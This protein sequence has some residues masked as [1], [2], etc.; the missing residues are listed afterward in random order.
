MRLNTFLKSFR[1]F[2]FFSFILIA[3]TLAAV[4]CGEKKEPQSVMAGYI[5]VKCPEEILPVISE[6][7]YE[8]MDLYVKSKILVVSSTTN[9]ALSAIFTDSAQVAV[10]T[11]PMSPVERERA[12]A[13]AF[14]V[15]EF[16]IAKDGIAVIV[17]Q[18]N[19]VR[20][21]TVEQ[22][23]KIFTG[24]ITNWSQVGGPNQAIRVC[25]WD[26][27]SGTHVYVKDSILNGK[28]FTAKA[29]RFETTEK[30]IRYIY[31]N[32]S[33][34]GLVSMTRL[35]QSWSP[36]IEDMRIKALAIGRSAIGPFV[37]PDGKTV[38]EG[39][40]PFVRHI[41]IYTARKPT[42]LD[43]GFISFIMAT[44]GQKILIQN[45]LVPITIPVTYE[46]DSL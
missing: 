37:S 19:P 33:G 45:G 46:K 38:H 44:A 35:Y 29:I 18:V 6:E 3:A 31:E 9:Q 23:I 10:T 15:N 40:Y 22:V 28:D 42:G 20:Q 1:H 34:I 11:R 36:L 25:S 26:E 12:A 7:A 21:L 39:L 2:S 14:S 16:K 41:Y 27:N 8:F 24:A 4:N 5:T 17:N 30:M 13:A 43:S 32:P